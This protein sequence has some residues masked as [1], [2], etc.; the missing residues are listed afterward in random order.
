MTPE[1]KRLIT[2]PNGLKG[3][4]DGFN[5]DIWIKK[6]GYSRLKDTREWCSFY[7][8]LVTVNAKL[9]EAPQGEIPEE[10]RGKWG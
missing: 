7:C 10:Q 4:V 9:K 1:I 3:I 6:G 2:T 5:A 8:A